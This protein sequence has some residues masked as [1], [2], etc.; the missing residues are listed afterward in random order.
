MSIRTNQSGFSA[1]E[2]IIVLAV[3]GALGFV[4]YSVYNRQNAQTTVSPD[5]DTSQAANSQ[6]SK[7]NDVASAPKI[8]STS[9]L[10]KASATLDQTNPSGSNNTDASQLDS[11][12][13]AF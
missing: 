1:F 12:L 8:S 4:G 6:S 9:D 5:T 13:T 11:Q 3:V 10:D 7:A 2:L